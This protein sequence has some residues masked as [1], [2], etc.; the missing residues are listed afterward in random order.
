MS[1][2][3]TRLIVLALLAGAL[4]VIATTS[5]SFDGRT[6]AAKLVGQLD[7]DWMQTRAQNFSLET[8]QGQSAKL[9]DYTGKVVLLNF[10]A[11]FCKPCLEEL[12]S[13]L[14]L[15]K[16]YRNRPLATVAV[17]QDPR[18]STIQSFVRTR[19]PKPLPRTLNI[20]WDPDNRIAPQWGTRQI[21]ETYVIDKQGR[22]VARL[23]SAYDWMRPDVRRLLD[24]LAD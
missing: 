8:L 16:D 12:P 9:K 2:K 18:R 6:R 11:T 10:W 23:V 15:Q 3:S 19:M 1:P 24:T 17:S 20:L 5:W 7:G 13:L 4:T 14:K 22:V 21:P